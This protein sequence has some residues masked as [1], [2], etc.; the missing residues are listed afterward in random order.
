MRINPLPMGHPVTHPVPIRLTTP[1]LTPQ[2]HMDKCEQEIE[3]IPATATRAYQPNS[4]ACWGTRRH[5]GEPLSELL[6]VLVPIALG[7]L[8]HTGWRS[9][10]KFTSLGSPWAT[11]FPLSL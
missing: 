5:R 10:P 4:Q 3:S 8:T 1:A 2:G 11:C 7:C 6:K 9:K